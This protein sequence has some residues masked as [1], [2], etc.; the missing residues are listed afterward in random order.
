MEKE[1]QACDRMAQFLEDN[2]TRIEA[3]GLESGYHK[4]IGALTRELLMYIRTKRRDT[5]MWLEFSEF[6]PPG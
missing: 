2:A 6:L 1:I 4:E 3:F 5:A